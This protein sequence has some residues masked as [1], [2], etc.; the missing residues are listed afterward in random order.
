[1]IEACGYVSIEAEHYSDMLKGD[2]GSYWGVIKS[3][4]HMSDTMK[5]L[6]DTAEHTTD[7]NSTARLIYNVY[8][9]NAG[10][11]PLTLK[12]LP[13]LNEGKENGT[14]RSMDVAVGVE[15]NTPVTLKGTRFAEYGNWTNILNMSETLK[16]NITVNKG[17]NK[18]VVYRS[19]ASFVFDRMVIETIK[20][21]VAKSVLGPQESPNNIC[22]TVYV[23][24]AKLPKKLETYNPETAIVMGSFNNIGMN[25]NESKS[26]D[27]MV[28]A[29]NGSKVTV[30][31]TSDD[32]EMVTA[33]M[34]D[35]K[36][37]LTSKEKTGNVM[38]S[39]TASAEGCT[40]VKQQF[41]VNVR[42]ASL[43][44]F[45]IESKGEV[46]INAA[47]AVLETPYSWT[48]VT[49]PGVWEITSDKNGV[50]LLPD[51]NTQWNNTNDLSDA[52]SLNF[53][54]KIASKGTYYLFANMS[55]PNDNADSYHVIV[56][57]VYRYTH[58]NG[59]MSGEKIWRSA[60]KGVELTAGEHTITIAAR[61]DGLV[62]NQI[63]LT[64]NK[65]K[66]LK[67]GTLEPVSAQEK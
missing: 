60:G 27:C 67:D 5:A 61:E 2:D 22:D 43:G 41:R 12:R 63:L 36:L 47:D 29:T 49:E 13:V 40:Q 11:Y 23:K 34:K 9:E 51:I 17:W 33:E 59:N 8:F 4:G 14:D 46:V 35:N 50:K 16:C 25:Q 19:D 53:R 65:D 64:T 42:N 55:N 18:I 52:P 56:D 1:Y 21:A 57:G 26:V 3:N 37:I 31:A 54:V 6:D 7:W 58:N 39:V 62:M 45:Y 28:Y 38:V 66:S 44:G 32:E 30:S 15:D 20:G 24:A 10:T 48:E